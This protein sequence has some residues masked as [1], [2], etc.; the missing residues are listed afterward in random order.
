[1]ASVPADQ[2]ATLVMPA[3]LADLW[4]SGQG[5]RQAQALVDVLATSGLAAAVGLVVDSGEVMVVVSVTALPGT[6]LNLSGRAAAGYR[7]Y[8]L[9]VRG[10]PGLVATLGPATVF[11]PAGEGLNA[12]V[13][14]G[15]ARAGRADPYEVLL[16]VPDQTALTLEQY[17]FLL[18][19]VE[20]VAPAGIQVNTLGLRRRHLDLDGDG[21]ADPLPPVS[22]HVY[23]RFQR[24]GSTHSPLPPGG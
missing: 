19:V 5:G 20:R 18:N 8:C 7:W 10:Q 15:Y 21:E 23:R 4:R 22:T 13:V 17:E 3:A 24:P 9:P 14:L 1:M 16:D 6:G 2:A 12:L 11:R